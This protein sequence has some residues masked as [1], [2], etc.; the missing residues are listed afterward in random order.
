MIDPTADYSPGNDFAA[1]EV[2]DFE[3]IRPIGSGGFGQVWLAANRATGHLRAVKVIALQRSDRTDAAG[4]E[5]ASIARL[6]KNVSTHH[7]NLLGI[8][9]VGKTPEHL[10][11]VMDPADDLSGSAASTDAGYRPASLQHRLDAKPLSSEECYDYAEQLLTGLAHLHAAGMVHRDVKPANCLFVDGVLKLADFGLLTEASPLVSRLGTQKYMPPDGRMDTRADVYAAGLVIYEMLTA[12]PADA[13]P[14]LGR[15][16]G[17][18]ATDPILA[19]LNRLA[20]QACQPVPAERFEDA[21][22][23][24]RELQRPPQQ[25]ARQRRRWPIAAMVAVVAMAVVAL[26]SV[27]WWPENTQPVVPASAAQ[28]VDVSFITEPYEATIYL[29]GKLLMNSHDKPH[30]TPCTVPDLPAGEHRVEFKH[31]QRGNLS[32]TVQLTT[33]CEVTARFAE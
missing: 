26:A 2:P 4:R 17:D 16:A 7:P 3:M 33:D 1:P 9:H 24:L 20:L 28:R 15:R 27:K 14:Q 31:P 25:A 8:H 32:R 29:D 19:H 13:F 30:T 5:V 23:M 12:R 21:G 11:Y 18:V 22:Q 6:E 10:F